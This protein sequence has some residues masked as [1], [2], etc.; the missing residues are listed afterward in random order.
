MKKILLS[1]MAAFFAMVLNAQ[2]SVWDGT[3]EPWSQGSGTQEDPYLIESAQNLAYLSEA[4]NKSYSNG[5]YD[6]PAFADTCFLLTV[7]VDLRGDYGLEI[8]PNPANTWVAVDYTLHEGFNNAV[9]TLTNNMGLEVYTQNVQ[10]E[11]GRHVIDL[12]KLPVGVYILTIKCEEHSLTN[13]LVV[14][15]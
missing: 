9:I 14:T 10:G 12:Q 3:A 7:D 15:R 2:V 1:T 8:H 6:T 11:C 4:V 5:E 13:K